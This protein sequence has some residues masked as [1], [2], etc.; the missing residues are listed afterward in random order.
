MEP[1]VVLPTGR[2]GDGRR[3]LTGEDSVP[4]FT[5]ETLT[6]NTRERTMTVI[7]S[8][9]GRIQPGRF[10]EYL[11][12]NRQ[13]IKIHERMGVTARVFL[14]GPAGEVSGLSSFSTEHAN[15]DDYGR[16]A[17]E[18]AADGELQS[19]VTHLRSEKAP[20]VIE[21]RQSQPVAATNSV[22]FSDG[23]I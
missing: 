3:A 22:N 1:F 23:V 15:M 2:K 21:Q 6:L 12:L 16:Y 10:D 20:V 18:A 14:A 8:I 13:V 4:V 19:L 9:I 17:D 5:A 11:E 7:Q